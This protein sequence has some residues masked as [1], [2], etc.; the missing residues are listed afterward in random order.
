MCVSLP[1]PDTCSLSLC[2]SECV[3]VCGLC[4]CVCVLGGGS[5][6]NVGLLVN[7]RLYIANVG[8]TRA[9]LSRGI[10]SSVLQCGAVRC[11]VMPCVAVY[12]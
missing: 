10:I 4:M 2:V 11:R 9:V 5:T 3:C 1:S 6:A 7:Q 8:D 12:W